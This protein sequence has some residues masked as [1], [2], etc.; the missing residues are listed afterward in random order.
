MVLAKLLSVF[1]LFLLSIQL[2]AQKLNSDELQK[3]LS[4][5]ET[6]QIS[7]D[8]PNAAIEN[9]AIVG[10]A[11]QRIGNTAIEEGR[12]TD[13]VKYLNQSIKYLDSA[14]NRTNLAV[15]YLR[16]NEF[17]K[18][19]SEA[20][21]AV[22]MNPKY[23]NSH[24]ILG[25][26]YFTKGEYELAMPP[27]EKVLLLA[28]DFDSVR[29]LGITY[30]HLKQPQR[31]KL[32]FE[33]IIASLKNNT[34]ELHNS[35]GQA[36]EQANYPLEAEREFKTA[37]TIN[38]KQPRSNFFLGYVILQHGGSERLSEAADAFAKELIISPNDF[39]ANFFAGVVASSE[40][41]HEKAISF[42]K[43]AAQI[44]PK[45]GEVYLFLGQSQFELNDLIAAEKNLRLA[46]Q[47][48][49][50]D[51]RSKSQANRTHFLLGRLLIKT[52]RKVEGEKELAISRKFQQESLDSAKS[53]INQI[54]GQVVEKNSS[55]TINAQPVVSLTPKRIAELKSLKSYLSNVLAQAFNNLGVIATQNG[56]IEDAISFFT[57]ALTWNPSFPNLNRNLGI[58]SFRSGQYDKAIQPLSNHLKLNPNDNLI[59][60]L[61]GTSYYSINN[62]A[63]TIE[64]LKPIETILTNEKELTYFYGIAL[65]QQKRNAEAVIIFNK[66]AQISQ[67]NPEA[68]FYAAQGYMILGDYERAVK[69]FRTVISLAPETSKANFFIG[70]S[71]IRLNRFAEAEKVFSR[72]L[73]INPN[74]ASSKYHIALTLIERK[75]EVEK[76]IAILEEAINLRFDYA[77]ALYQLGKIF[78]EKGETEKAIEKL[79]RAVSTNSNKDY[80]HY[81]LSIAYRKMQ[82]KEDADRELK[83]YQK[84][85]AE[86][87]KLETLSPMGANENLP[88]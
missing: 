67:K 41:K 31:T 81:Q 18:A 1:L 69:E 7:G 33:E 75:I 57:S 19:I 17:D 10:I 77:D 60:Q 65:I 37:L 76:T 48:E 50:T 36:Y 59:R 22:E 53:Q 44:D 79:E 23:A 34:P 84:L 29:A 40:N 11:L 62:F 85:K 27:L 12:N 54:L 21:L 24:Y 78:L 49:K 45:R 61:L 14:E 71:L 68:L 16:L 6:F 35:F 80:I 42:L 66:L 2:N 70:Q 32:L 20:K 4:A 47:L 82:R 55:Q 30:L 88:K 56:Q 72:E 87:R 38:P 64:I 25:N 39:Y 58:L 13:A 74:D 43:K 28:P 86:N 63:K 46:I 83:I 8:L 3:H 51:E 26:L 52:N 9:Q 73:E 5:A 15:A